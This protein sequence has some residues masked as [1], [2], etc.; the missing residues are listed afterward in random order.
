MLCGVILTMSSEGKSLGDGDAL[1]WLTPWR[2][3]PTGPC[4]GRA[5]QSLEGTLLL[6]YL[7][8][9]PVARSLYY[10]FIYAEIKVSLFYS[11]PRSCTV[12]T[13]RAVLDTPMLYVLKVTLGIT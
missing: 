8:V 7:F 10:I 5:C 12:H 9:H 6:Y 13:L 4:R 1:R 2:F 3:E 11:S